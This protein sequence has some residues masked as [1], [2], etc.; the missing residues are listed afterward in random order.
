MKEKKKKGVW[1][2]HQTAK[3]SSLIRNFIQNTLLKTK[4]EA[5]F[6]TDFNEQIKAQ[7]RPIKPSTKL[8]PKF[9]I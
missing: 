2:H 4:P 1:N 7:I 3:K 5:S 9:K 6:L 8:E